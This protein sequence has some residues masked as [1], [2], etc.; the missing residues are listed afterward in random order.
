MRSEVAKIE[1]VTRALGAMSTHGVRALVVGGIA[2]AVHGGKSVT[3]DL[4]LHLNA[5]EREIAR[6]QRALADLQAEVIAVPTELR[7]EYLERGFWIHFEC[8]QPDVAGL[9]VDI[10][11][12]PFGGAPYLREDSN[13]SQ[14]RTRTP[15]FRGVCW[16]QL[17]LLQQAR[18]GAAWLG[19]PLLRGGCWTAFDVLGTSCLHD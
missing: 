14:F 2:R 7:W 8:H 10:A 4:D 18:R 15:D 12:R 1:A 9:H 6:V 13:G 19:N 16:S 5:D 3:K 11:T 17:C